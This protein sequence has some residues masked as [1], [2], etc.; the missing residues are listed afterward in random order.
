MKRQYQENGSLLKPLLSM[1]NSSKFTDIIILTAI[2]NIYSN[3][4]HLLIY[5]Y[6]QSLRTIS[7]ISNW[8]TY[9]SIDQRT[10]KIDN[11]CFKYKSTNK[12]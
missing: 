6:I 11:K 7:S 9:Y 5:F 8:E 2:A 12:I 4:V 1:R 10:N 3:N